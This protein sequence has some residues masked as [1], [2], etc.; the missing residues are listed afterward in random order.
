MRDLFV[1]LLDAR[2]L[3][4]Y[5]ENEF[6]EL[7]QTL[8]NSN[9]DNTIDWD[10]GAGEEWAFVNNDAYSVMLN[11]RIGIC[12]VRGVLDEATDLCLSQC[13]CVSVDGFDIKEWHIDLADLRKSI[14]EIKWSASEAAVDPNC[15]SLNDFFVATV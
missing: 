15:F 7:L 10:L 2:N 9:E 12:F 14:P 13:R 5:K 4:I 6:E 8:E 3:K 1:E 11:R